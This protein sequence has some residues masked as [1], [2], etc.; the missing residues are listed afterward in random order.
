MCL[1]EISIQEFKEDFLAFR[2]A[3]VDTDSLLQTCG[4]SPVRM[5]YKADEVTVMDVAPEE[6]ILKSGESFIYINQI[7]KIIKYKS[8]DV[9]RSYEIL[10]GFVDD[11][12]TTVR[13][14]QVV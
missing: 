14:T 4:A 8:D 13:I 2:E 6:I 3:H 5:C 9:M 10:C 11:F 1:K 12:E 7:K